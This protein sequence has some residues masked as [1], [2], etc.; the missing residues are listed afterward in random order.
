MTFARYLTAAFLLS[1]AL[2]LTF[3]KNVSADTELPS[4]K[5]IIAR[6]VE[7]MGAYPATENL[8]IRVTDSNTQTTRYLE[9]S[10]EDGIIAYNEANG[11]V[12]I[13]VGNFDK[14]WQ[15]DDVLD[16]EIGLKE[17]GCPPRYISTATISIDEKPIQ[18]FKDSEDLLLSW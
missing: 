18:T 1:S 16:V 3:P 12:T 8:V 2:A 10:N 15:S 14:P 5:T 13:V 7:K 9:G 17:E 11:L 6:M 4:L